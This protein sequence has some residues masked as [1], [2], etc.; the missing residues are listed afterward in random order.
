MTDHKPLL[1]IFSPS[2]ATPVLAANRLARWALQLSQYTYTV[3]YRKTK[4]HRNVDALSCLPVGEDPNFDGEEDGNDIDMVCTIHLIENQLDTGELSIKKESEMDSI[5]ST[6]MRYCCDG[7]P[8]ETQEEK[9]TDLRLFRSLQDSLST[10]Q[11]CLFHG[12]RSV[13]PSSIRDKVLKILHLGHLGSRKMKQLGRT[14]V[15]WP[16]LIAT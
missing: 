8:A 1:S 5:I 12:N 6:V 9:K 11:G 7:W 10:S 4:D 16:V 14:A 13:I 15:Y 2:K 3:E